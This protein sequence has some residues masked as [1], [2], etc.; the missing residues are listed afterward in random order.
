MNEG[1]K[2]IYDTEIMW[3]FYYNDNKKDKSRIDAHYE[4]TANKASENLKNVFA[5]TSS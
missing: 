1:K 3:K 4:P 2:E 5:T